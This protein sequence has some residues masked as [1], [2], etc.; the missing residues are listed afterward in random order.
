MHTRYTVHR[1][2]V[3]GKLGLAMDEPE[4]PQDVLGEAICEA[5]ECP[6]LPAQP[7]PADLV[8]VGLQAGLTGLAGG[9]RLLKLHKL[10]SDLLTK[11]STHSD[12]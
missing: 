11:I 7:L 1:T 8:E 9:E 5:S 4:R 12:P 6:G 10:L 2:P 3:Q